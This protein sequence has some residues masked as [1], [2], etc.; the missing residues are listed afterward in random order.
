LCHYQITKHLLNSK[1]TPH[2]DFEVPA[3]LETLILCMFQAIST[4]K[5]NLS[6]YVKIG[7]KKTETD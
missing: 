4:L 2:E 5:D 7:L 1:Q 6:E 3:G